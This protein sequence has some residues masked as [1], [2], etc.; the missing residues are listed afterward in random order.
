MKILI[1]LTALEDNF[2]GIERFCSN[3]ALNLVKNYPEDLFILIFK[4]KIPK[5]FQKIKKSTNITTVI[6]K[7]KHKLFFSQITLPYYLYKFKADFYLFMAFPAPLL[8]FNKNSITT[9]HDISCWDFPQTMKFL[10]KYYFRISYRKAVLLN[11]TVMTVSNFSKKRIIEKLGCKS[12][13][14]LV[15]N[16]GL[17]KV[18]LNYIENND[19]E[20]STMKKYNIP[21]KYLLCLSTLEPRKNL[22][23]LIEAYSELLLNKEIDMKLVLAGRKGWK[24]DNLMLNLNEEVVNNIYF[25]G[26]IDDE[27]LPIIYKKAICFVFPSLYEGFGIPPLEAMFMKT[28]VLS[29]DAASLPEVLGNSAHYFDSGSKEDL[30]KNILEILQKTNSSSKHLKNEVE[31]LRKK[32]NWNDSSINLHFLLNSKKLN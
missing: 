14:V 5:E 13:N 2:S 24:I 1:D 15:I 23:L 31:Y 8:F 10:S 4:N 3:I 22:R 21:E 18:F 16:N 19:K 26:F 29:S 30:K 32:Y 11:K 28:T 6:V 12:K 20:K 9:I 17:S 25:T 7:G 27:D